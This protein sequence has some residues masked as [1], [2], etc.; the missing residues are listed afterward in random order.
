[1]II[2]AW[3]LGQQ[4]C[5]FVYPFLKRLCFLIPTAD[6]FWRM[7]CLLILQVFDVG[8][9]FSFCQS[10]DEEGEEGGKTYV[11]VIDENGI[12]LDDPQQ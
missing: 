3:T 4:C 10:D 9:T 11:V 2:M 8:S 6:S 12:Q 5:F 1:M 7:I